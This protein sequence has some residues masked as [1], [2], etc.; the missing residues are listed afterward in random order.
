MSHGRIR[1]VFVALGFVAAAAAPT[2]AFPSCR[3][4]CNQ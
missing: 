3:G 1:K 2:Y 4:H